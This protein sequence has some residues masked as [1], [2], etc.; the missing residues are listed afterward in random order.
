MKKP[1]SEFLLARNLQK[2][3]SPLTGPD[4]FSQE[5]APGCACAMRIKRSK[6]RFSVSPA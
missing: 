5:T 1:I 4:H 2:K 6:P 3:L